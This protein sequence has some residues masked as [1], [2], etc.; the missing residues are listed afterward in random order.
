MGIPLFFGNFIKSNRIKHVINTGIPK[1]V[2]SLSF[3]LNS[4]LHAARALVYD[5]KDNAGLNMMQLEQL[6]FITIATIIMDMT[7]KCNPRDTLILA[8]DGIAPLAKMTQQRSRRFRSALENN[9]DTQIFDRNALTPGTETMI[10]LS[11][12]LEGFIEQNKDKLPP[13]VI[14]SSHMV[15]GEGEHKIM[16]FIRSGELTNEPVSKAGGAH[17]INALDADLILLSMLAPINHI[18]LVRENVKESINIDKFRDYLRKKT[19]VSTCLDDF[20]VMMNLIGN[21]FL[22]HG[23]ALTNLSESVSLMLDKYSELGLPLTK[24]KTDTRNSIDWNN[25]QVFISSISVNESQMLDSLA[26]K[27]YKFPSRFFQRSFVNNQF[28]PQIFRQLWYI[29]EFWP[30]NPENITQEIMNII[31]SYN[32]SQINIQEKLSDMTVDYLRTMEWVYL[33]YREGTSAINKNWCYRYY[34]TPLLSDLNIGINIVLQNGMFG[35]ER[36]DGFGNFNVLHQ[37]ISVLPVK[38]S[39]LLPIELQQLMTFNSMIRDLFPD[40]FITELDGVNKEHQGI[41]LVPFIDMKRIVEAVS[42]VYFSVERLALFT[43]DTDKFYVRE[44]D[45]SIREKAI[46]QF[47]Q[48]KKE[49]EFQNN[50]FRGSNRG[51]FTRGDRGGFSRGDRGNFSRGDRGG[52]NR[53]NFNRG[54]FNRGDRGGFNRGNR[55]NFTRGKS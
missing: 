16:D 30:K 18:Y 26:R 3:D 31:P 19:G 29:N 42:S 53:G 50:N 39:G 38:S 17:L 21:D 14:Y 2:S 37:L 23:P 33:Y 8:I 11:S 46:E 45:F 43:E 49:R 5:N 27:E 48:F 22:P 41:V 51:N 4:V 28:Q 52:F 40:N 54:E 44:E 15:P 7:T 32:P 55:G 36:I 24:K 20:V 13:K 1:F 12:F 10:K 25:M 6:H 9:T 34:H 35:Y 47:E